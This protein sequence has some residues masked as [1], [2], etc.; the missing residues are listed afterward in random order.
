MSSPIV[1]GLQS[2]TPDEA[3]RYVADGWWSTEGLVAV[4]DRHAR[5]DPEGTAWIGDGYA[6]TW[7]QVRAASTVVAAVLDRHGVGRDTPVA[8]LLA[9]SPIV[10][11]VY[12]GIERAG[13]VIVGIGPR[14][15]RREV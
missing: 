10:H 15:G 12:L 8:V 11:A 5:D 4:L 14:A 9:D 7:A 3:A 6:C 2:A 13:A 1:P